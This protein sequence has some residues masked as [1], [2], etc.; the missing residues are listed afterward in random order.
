MPRGWRPRASHVTGAHFGERE[1]KADTSPLL[2]RKLRYG[3]SGLPPASSHWKKAGAVTSYNDCAVGEKCVCA[4]S[5]GHRGDLGLSREFWPRSTR[6]AYITEKGGE[7]GY[8]NTYITAA[9]REQHLV[10]F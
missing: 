4:T 5:C 3:Y 1:A 2:L 6:R 8:F 9:N 10:V 7:V